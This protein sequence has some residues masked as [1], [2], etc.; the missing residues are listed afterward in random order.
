MKKFLIGGILFLMVGMV[1]LIA[2]ADDPA[3]GVGK[4]VTL[5]YTLIVDN[6]QVETSI[7]KT[8]LVSI[9]AFNSSSRLWRRN[10]EPSLPPPLDCW[11]GAVPMA[12]PRR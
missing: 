10:P 2:Y 3:V 7:G 1:N 9:R 5:D 6:K 12:P 4:K 11:P 8:P